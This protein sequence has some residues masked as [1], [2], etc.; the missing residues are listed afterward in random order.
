MNGLWKHISTF[1]DPYVVPF[2]HPLH[3]GKGNGLVRVTLQIN[4]R[5]L[6]AALSPIRSVQC[7]VTATSL[8][9]DGSDRLV[10]NC[11]DCGVATIGQRRCDVEHRT[12]CP[13]TRQNLAK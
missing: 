9:E 13:P 6:A 7:E 3:G 1:L 11:S 4:G 8:N 5:S 10:Q 12:M 2:I